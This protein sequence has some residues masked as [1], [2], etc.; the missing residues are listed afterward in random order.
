MNI[1]EELLKSNVN[2]DFIKAVKNTNIEKILNKGGT[3]ES[4]SVRDKRK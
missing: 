1:I 4:V 3:N 2:K